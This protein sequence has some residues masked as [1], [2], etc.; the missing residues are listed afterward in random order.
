MACALSMK[1]DVELAQFNPQ[2]LFYGGIFTV[3][4]QLLCEISDA[5][6][7]GW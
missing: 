1:F 4:L 6:V 5:Y 7:D 2:P 3:Y